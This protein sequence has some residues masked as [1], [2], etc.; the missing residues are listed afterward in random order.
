LADEKQP[1]KVAL[2]VS[3][4]FILVAA[5]CAGGNMRSQASGG[6]LQVWIDADPSIAPGG[7]EVDDGFALIQGFHSPELDIQGISTVFG[8]ADLPKAFSIAKEI[9]SRFGPKGL[10]VY[11]GASSANQLSEETPASR[12]LAD[13]LS[14]TEMT[15][16]AL[17][18]VTNISTVLKNHPELVRRIREVV[19]VAGRQP[20][21]HF[22]SSRKQTR[23][24][25]DLNFE[26]DPQSFQILLD[27]GVEIVLMPWEVSSK[28]W[29]REGDLKLLAKGND[30]TEWLWGPAEDWLHLWQKEFHLDAFNP[31]ATLTVGY[32][33][34]PRWFQ[35]EDFSV[36][37]RSL[38]DDVNTDVRKDK[39]YLLASKRIA[40]NRIVRYCYNV[41]PEFKKDLMK[42]L[43]QR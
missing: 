19:V 33:L 14:R 12:A 2:V 31:S 36:E 21:Q 25:R 5:V 20:E 38:P 32:V 15:L 27:S 9:V 7:H 10:Q 29:L 4:L 43:L 42:R 30:A 37:I 1:H 13:A 23:P 18:P 35:W 17:G 3:A 16:L 39:P 22:R 11:E 24:L 40:S 26:M 28:V 41:S 8:N 6:R 34:S